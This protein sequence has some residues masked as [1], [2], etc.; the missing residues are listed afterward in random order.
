MTSV[1]HSSVSSRF[2]TSRPMALHLHLSLAAHRCLHLRSETFAAD[3]LGSQTH[4]EHT[5]SPLLSLERQSLTGRE[6]LLA[7]RAGDLGQGSDEVPV[8]AAAMPP[9]LPR[10]S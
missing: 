4:A 6:F 7:L 8:A 3:D 1:A 9:P 10:A 2:V 5:P